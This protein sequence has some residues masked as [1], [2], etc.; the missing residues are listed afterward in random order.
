MLT[1]GHRGARGHIAENTIESIKKALEFNV[2]G[3]EIDVFCCA[4][5]E[6]VVFHDENLNRLTGYKGLIEKTTL[7]ELNKI[8]VDGKYK[9]PT[10]EEVINLVGNKILLNIELKGKNTAIPTSLILK[11]S[12]NTLKLLSETLIVSSKDW[13]ELEVFKNQNT[14]IPIALLSD[15]HIVLEKDIFMMAKKLDAI[16]LHPRLSTLSKKIVDKIHSNGL[17]VNSWT[18]NSPRHIKKAIDYGVDGIISDY[19]D[20]VKN[21]V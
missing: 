7:E 12:I 1:I 10:L 4:T 3:I 5:G 17:L 6:V 11:K 13:Y 15:S 20:R 14:D 8:L 18:I 16:A 9:I 19:P 2:D 21:L